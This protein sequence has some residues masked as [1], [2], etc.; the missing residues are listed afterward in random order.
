[1]KADVLDDFDTI[2]VCTHYKY[3]DTQEVIDFM[4]YDLTSRDVEP[5]YV[6]RKGWKTDLTKLSSINQIPAELND[7]V[8]YLE[9]ELNVPIT[10]VSV[11]PDRSQTLI[12][13]NVLV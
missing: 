13:E 9:K 6:D 3:K 10:I 5:I 1:M 7:Y 2:K 12:R 4:P 8:E 11:G